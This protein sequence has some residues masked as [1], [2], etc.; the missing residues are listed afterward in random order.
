MTR[1]HLTLAC[2]ALLAISWGFLPDFTV[3]LF[4]YIALYALV[5]AGLVN[6]QI[7]R[8]LDISMWTVAAHLNRAFIKLGDN[9]PCT[10]R[11]KG[12][13]IRS[14]VSCQCRSNR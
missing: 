14:S 4:S 6:K 5:A 13:F 12:D 10:I 9:D 2:V 1:R 8:R 3:T 11:C 7:A